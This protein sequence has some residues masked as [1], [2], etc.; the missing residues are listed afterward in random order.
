MSSN[1]RILEGTMVYNNLEGGFW[2][3]ISNYGEKYLL[4]QN[5][6]P[7]NIKYHKLKVKVTVKPSVSTSIYMWG[8]YVVD[9]TGLLEIIETSFKILCHTR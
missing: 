2:G 3:F 8:N 6:I 5:E 9:F 7:E 1:E 4:N